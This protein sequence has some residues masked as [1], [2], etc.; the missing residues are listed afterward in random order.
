[1]ALQCESA[2]SEE[3]SVTYYDLRVRVV[4]FSAALTN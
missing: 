3:T 1:M 4:V 2:A